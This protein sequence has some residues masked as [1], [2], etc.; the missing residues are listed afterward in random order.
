MDDYEVW[1]KQDAEQLDTQE[2]EQMFASLT[3]RVEGISA[4]VD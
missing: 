3:K 1:M 2:K 4:I